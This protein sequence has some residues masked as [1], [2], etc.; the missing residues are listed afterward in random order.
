MTK[1]V[2]IEARPTR[3]KVKNLTGQEIPLLSNI[4]KNF[5][6]EARDKYLAEFKFTVASDLRA[7]DRLLLLEVQMYRAQWFLSAGCDYQYVDLDPAEEVALR[8]T[9]KEASAQIQEIQKDLGLIKSTRDKEQAD[10]VGAYITKLKL[11][12]KAHGIKRER[13]LGR[14]LELTH[15]LFALCGA[16]QRSNE[17]ERNKLGFESADD[18]VEWVMTYMR[19]EFNAIDDYFREHEQ[20]FW[21]REL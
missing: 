8:R 21:V 2:S 7:L 11:A 4:E 16:Y 17:H 10:S 12:A 1:D 15:E 5:Y 20:R 3:F 14:A 19:E 18:I 9:V 13:E 6:I